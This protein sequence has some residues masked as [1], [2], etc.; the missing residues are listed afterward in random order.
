ML[1]LLTMNKECNLKKILLIIY[2]SAVIF[3]TVAQVFADDSNGQSVNREY[4]I[5]AG[6]LYNFFGFIDWPGDK[7]VNSAASFTI[8]VICNQ[9]KEEFK[10]ELNRL[11]QKTVNGKPIKVRVFDK[12]NSTLSPG[13]SDA[14]RE[15]LIDSLKKC[16]II[17]IC[18][19]DQGNPSSLTQFLKLFSG[20]G[21]LTVGHTPG[22]I[23]NGGN[24]NFISEGNKIRFE[25]NID[26]AKENK[27]SIRAKLLKLA[28]RVISKDGEHSN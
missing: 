16:H 1:L 19:F 22:F 15:E 24:I 11:E 9:S 26:T 4:Q 3:G 13:S 6:Y 25:I 27:L 17:M 21:V 14:D 2:V 8:G 5:K 7:N 23:D 10:A 28:K 18:Q 12:I 20:C